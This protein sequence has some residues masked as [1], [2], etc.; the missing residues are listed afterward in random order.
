[1]RKTRAA[2]KLA[3]RYCRQHEDQ[4]RADSCANSLDTKGSRKFWENLYK[5]SNNRASKFATTV[6]GVSGDCDTSNMWKQ[7]FEKLYNSVDC[8]NDESIFND[9]LNIVC[10]DTASNTINT[11]DIATALQQQKKGKYTGPDG[12]AMEAFINGS[13]KLL[14]HLA[15]LFTMFVDHRYVPGKFMH[16]IIIPLVKCKGG[17]LADVNN[18]WAI[19]LSNLVTKLFESVIL[20]KFQSSSDI[21]A[22]QFGFKKGHSTAQCTGAMLSLTASQLKRVHDR[23][24]FCRH[25]FHTVHSR[26]VASYCRYSHRLQYCWCN[27]KCFS[28]CR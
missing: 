19:T 5:V 2:F 3:L 25:F 14:V 6:G 22:Y 16:S 1:M 21:D 15:I 27:G 9:R 13:S 18:Y 20:N 11:S 8:S 10:F 28:L 12:I 4:L 23:E 7:H 17:T 24:D 26:T